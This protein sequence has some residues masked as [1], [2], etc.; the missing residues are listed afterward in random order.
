MKKKTLVCLF[1]SLLA[2]ALVACGADN[3]GSMDDDFASDTEFEPSDESDSMED[4]IKAS[5]DDLSD[6]VSGARELTFEDLS[7]Y[8]FELCSGA[9]GW[10]ED[11]YIETDGSLHGDYHDSDM[12]DCGDGYPDG[13]LYWCT[14]TGKFGNLTR[15]DAYTYEVT[16]EDL[17]Y[18]T[19]R[20][21]E[22]IRDDIRYIRTESSALGGNDTF[23]IYLPGKKVSDLNE[24]VWWW[25]QW[26]NYPRD[27]YTSQV[28]SEKLVKLGMGDVKN[29]L[30]MYALVR[31]SP[32]EEAQSCVK[33]AQ[34]NYEYGMDYYKKAETTAEMLDWANYI[35][36]S[37]DG[38]LNQ[39]W[40]IVKA[41]NDEATYAKI[42]DDQ[43]QWIAKKEEAGEVALNAGGSQA[44]VD[45]R[46]VMAD[47]TLE[48]CQELLK[49]V[50][51]NK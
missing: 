13:T 46:L 11:F 20:P 48:R 1:V 29:E 19:S 2:L 42:L 7:K 50:P 40:T 28:D 26:N 8:C 38:C 45:Q 6:V 47:M 9:G 17:Q 36:D 16:L 23:Q 33:T 43:R 24:A 14:Y 37:V 51:Q 27:D 5:D 39:M 41:N 25:L 4:D 18:D 22:E 34:Y 32:Y 12:G 44:M 21:K 30:G 15:V 31:L 35:Y 3:S 10:S 49:Y